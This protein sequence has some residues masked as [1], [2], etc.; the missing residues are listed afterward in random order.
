[1]MLKIID[2]YLTQ[3]GSTV[4]TI[5]AIVGNSF[6]FYILT[7]PKFLKESVFRY[8][9]VSEVTATLT[10]VSLWMYNIPTILGWN[11]PLVYCQS[12]VYVL[13]TLYKFYPWVT[14]L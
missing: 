12:L 6:V 7:R 4:L 5:I 10:L 9:L 11:V 2:K 8:F 13:Y 14:L 3:I 1:M